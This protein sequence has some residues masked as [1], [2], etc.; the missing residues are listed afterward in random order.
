MIL[1]SEALP[2]SISIAAVIGPEQP[3]SRDDPPGKCEIGG[4]TRLGFAG[5]A[6]SRAEFTSGSTYRGGWPDNR[7]ANYDVCAD[8]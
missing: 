7:G 1:Q 8:P 5:L 2:G 4:N 3:F 6:R